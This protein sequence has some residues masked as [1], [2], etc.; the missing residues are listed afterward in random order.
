MR[1]LRARAVR[2]LALS[3]L[4]LTSMA[5]AEMPVTERAL[6]KLPEK[7]RLVLSEDWS[8]G[9][10]EPQRWYTPRKKWGDGNH[11]VVPENV[12]IRPDTV[13]GRTQNVLVCRAHGDQYQGPIVGLGGKKTRVGALVVSKQFFASGR[14]EVVMKVGADTP[15]AGGPADPLRPAGTVPAIWTYGYRYVEVGRDRM[16]EFVREVPLYNPLMERYG[17]GSNEYWSEIDFPEYGM[18]GKFSPTMYNT[19][20]QNRHEAKFFDVDFAI[21]G[22]YHTYTTEWRTK[23]EPL[24]GVTDEQVAEHLGYWWVCDKSIPFERYLGNPLRRLGKDEYALYCG[25]IVEHWIDG[26]KVAENTRYVPAMAAQLN[27]GIWMPHW[28]GPAPWETAH[29]SFASVKVW[30]YDDP[31]DVR[32]VLIDDLKDTFDVEGR[33]K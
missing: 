16:Q 26:K 17:N 30:Q 20:L 13:A 23:L 18:Q 2:F 8:S 15:H 31:G 9:K 28:A 5:R 21:D 11:G 22:Q 19:F 29:V 14:F 7:A 27:L 33:E 4:G 32:N 12:S 10:L 3:V 1:N 6:P 24:D 25:A